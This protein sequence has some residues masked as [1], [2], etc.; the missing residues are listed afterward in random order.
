[1]WLIAVIFVKSQLS[2]KRLFVWDCWEQLSV[3]L[4]T[5]AGRQHFSNSESIRIIAAYICRTGSNTSTTLFKWS[6]M[7]REFVLTA[8]DLLRYSVVPGL[9]CL[10]S[11]FGLPSFFWAQT[12]VLALY[13][14]LCEV[15]ILGPVAKSS[16]HSALVS[17]I[18]APPSREIWSP[19]GGLGFLPVCSLMVTGLEMVTDAPVAWLVLYPAL[20]DQAVIAPWESMFSVKWGTEGH[21]ASI[22]LVTPALTRLLC[23]GQLIR[24]YCADSLCWC[25]QH[26]HT[27]NTP[28]TQSCGD[29]QRQLL[30]DSGL[31]HFL[32]PCWWSGYCF[33]Y[34]QL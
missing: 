16:K 12:S 18:P 3:Y 32:Q 1:M 19:Q 13:S 5:A 27:A 15:V 8:C 28:A 30:S 31:S 10:H 23:S 11:R 6:G 26:F 33:R 14:P 22:L 9:G 4:Q 29:Q 21:G 25:N 24:W 20:T 2:R 17:A 7:G 34:L